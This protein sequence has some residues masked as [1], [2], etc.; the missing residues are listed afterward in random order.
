MFVFLSDFRITCFAALSHQNE[1]NIAPFTEQELQEFIDW[2]HTIV[3]DKSIQQEFTTNLIRHLGPDATYSKKESILLSLHI[4]YQAFLDKK[5]DSD[6][7]YNIIDQAKNCTHGLDS[8]L[9]MYIIEYLKFPQCFEDLLAIARQNFVK[10][11]AIH[12]SSDVHVQ[13]QI[14][15]IASN[16]I[17]TE[18]SNFDDPYSL[19]MIKELEIKHDL[20]N[21]FSEF[22]VLF[23][24]IDTLEKIIYEWI[25]KSGYQDEVQNDA[26]T[27]ELIQHL[28]KSIF[29]H[30]PVV[31]N[32]IDFEQ[33]LKSN[34]PTRN[35]QEEFYRWR[36]QEDIKEA[37]DEIIT[38]ILSQTEST[39]FNC[40]LSA[41]QQQHMIEIQASYRKLPNRLHEKIKKYLQEQNIYFG[42][43]EMIWEN[44]T[45]R[46]TRKS[47]QVWFEHQDESLKNQ[48]Q[49]WKDAFIQQTKLQTQNKMKHF[50]YQNA[51]NDYFWKT[52]DNPLAQTHVLHK[53]NIR[54]AIW[55]SLLNHQYID[56]KPHN[57]RF[58]SKVNGIIDEPMEEKRSFF[59]ETLNFHSFSSEHLYLF[60]FL[61]LSQDQQSL[62]VL[63]QFL[64]NFVI[65]CVLSNHVLLEKILQTYK[66]LALPPSEEL[67]RAFDEI[68]Q[69]YK[70]THFT[71]LH[72]LI[73]IIH[74]PNTKLEFIKKWPVPENFSE[75]KNLLLKI[76]EQ[77][78]RLDLINHWSIFPS[79]VKEMNSLLR[80]IHKNQGLEFLVSRIALF[81]NPA[82][83]INILGEIIKKLNDEE[84]VLFIKKLIFSLQNK[85]IIKNA[86]PIIEGL[87]KEELYLN[88][89]R[90]I[91]NISFIETHRQLKNLITNRFYQDDFE[92]IIENIPKTLKKH[93]NNVLEISKYLCD[94]KKIQFFNQMMAKNKNMSHCFLVF[95]KQIEIEE[96]RMIFIKQNHSLLCINL[97]EKIIKD[98][99]FEPQNHQKLLFDFIKKSQSIFNSKIITLLIIA[100]K[101]EYFAVL[102]TFFALR[103]IKI[104][105]EEK[106]L[107]HFLFNKPISSEE[108]LD[109]LINDPQMIQNY[110]FMIAI[111]NEFTATQ[112]SIWVNQA[113]TQ[114]L[115]YCQ[116]NTDNLF[117]LLSCL[118]IN[119]EFDELLNQIHP[120]LI[121]EIIFITCDESHPNAQ[122]QLKTQTYL[123][124]YFLKNHNILKFLGVLKTYPAF[125]KKMKSFLNPSL[126]SLILLTP[127]TLSFYKENA[128]IY[129]EFLISSPEPQTIIQ[130]H[131][132]QSIT[133]NEWA[134]MLSSLELLQE[135]QFSSEHFNV[136]LSHLNQNE[137]FVFLNQYPIALNALLHLFHHEENKFSDEEKIHLFEQMIPLKHQHT[138]IIFKKLLEI[139][140]KPVAKNLFLKHLELTPEI[141][142]PLN[143]LE[144]GLINLNIHLNDIELHFNFSECFLKIQKISLI[145]SFWETLVKQNLNY[146]EYTKWTNLLIKISEEN[147]L[148]QNHVPY[149][150]VFWRFWDLLPANYKR[151]LLSFFIQNKPGFFWNSYS[152]N[153]ILMAE[154]S[155]KS[156]FFLE[157]TT[158]IDTSKHIQTFNGFINMY[159][160]IKSKNKQKN[161]DE[162][163]Y[164]FLRASGEKIFNNIISETELIEFFKL[165]TENEVILQALHQQLHLSPIIH[166]IELFNYFLY[167]NFA[168]QQN[169]L[170]NLVSIICEKLTHMPQSCFIYLDILKQKY[171]LSPLQ[172]FMISQ[173][174]TFQK[175]SFSNFNQFQI[176]YSTSPQWIFDVYIFKILEE[177]VIKIINHNYDFLYDFISFVTEQSK[178]NTERIEQILSNPSLTCIDSLQQWLA[179]KEFITP[180]FMIK[181]IFSQKSW[182]H[183]EINQA[184]YLCHDAPIL[185]TYLMINL[186]ADRELLAIFK[187][188]SARTEE[189]KQNYVD[190]YNNQMIKSIILN[191]LKIQDYLG[192]NHLILSQFKQILASKAN[193]N[194]LRFFLTPYYQ[195]IYQA[196]QSQ[197][198][199]IS[200]YDIENLKRDRDLNPYFKTSVINSF[201]E[202]LMAEN[203]FQTRCKI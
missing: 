95:L 16:L 120:D 175:I 84:K 146:T 138:P 31:K 3:T 35:I 67:L 53:I 22:Y 179:L 57:V 70:K 14:F 199:K 80:L 8:A 145:T 136:L 82:L 170:F 196:I 45:A 4:L 139:L 188:P 158:Y 76:P 98:L 104:R 74:H 29:S 43:K 153:K 91:I 108:V 189:Y 176:W 168:N 114:V 133:K 125:I 150:K 59:Q 5:I 13:N 166:L 46:L 173:K 169:I 105:H 55:H 115:A 119:A 21:K 156:S 112:N 50:E 202:E 131:F 24:I 165:D 69:S 164:A 17:Q 2:V 178:M 65:S 78:I 7:I 191:N 41:E 40:Y 100:F 143:I 160:Q 167:K 48:L 107:F 171:G 9:Q 11:F 197:D 63:N 122:N 144:F 201:F 187:N 111:M 163:K 141:F 61:G 124:E 193:Q 36:E 47:Y 79:D 126:I 23:Q 30:L 68:P 194:S 89:Y 51:F 102:N 12:Q 1:R 85:Q 174:E 19:N 54:R 38:G 109:I 15:L 73:K 20:N 152:F 56:I 39:E 116:K 148:N 180:E 94:Q 42:S 60:Q 128:W 127:D 6:L 151:Q 132:S 117:N 121:C 147:S 186:N 71:L 177:S 118:E 97:L 184:L 142:Q 28:F 58:I 92:Q 90:K 72:T 162:Y 123:F 96:Y 149:Q 110:E 52:S 182:T 155:L 26:E 198:I 154:N 83:E 77:N 113:K 32:L 135:N 137:L 33:E 25:Q 159:H 37:N 130:Q 18:A 64:G 10:N 86:H 87:F 192:L 103:N 93:L 134:Y 66:V 129:A 161:Y 190:N 75:L 101:T 34:P 172:N 81:K 183:E 203:G 27:L 181:N 200:P 157:L 185:E 49:T 99:I 106:N 140:P 88:Q 195:Q 62:Q 44:L